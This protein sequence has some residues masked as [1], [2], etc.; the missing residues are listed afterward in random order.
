MMII[1]AE[2]CIIHLALCDETQ[3]KQEETRVI[4]SKIKKRWREIIKA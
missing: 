4:E 2:L 3:R 1:R